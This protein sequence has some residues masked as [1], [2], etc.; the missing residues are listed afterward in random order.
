MNFKIDLSQVQD[1][2][3]PLLRYNPELDDFRSILAD[4]CDILEDTSAA[5]FVVSGFGQAS[6]PVDVGTDL[7]V[8]LEQIPD[9]ISSIDLGVPFSLDFYEQGLERKIHFTPQGETYS[10][11][12]ESWTAWRPDPAIEA[13]D[14]SLLRKMLSAI[15]ERFMN[16][17]SIK[18]P[19]VAAH[20]WIRTW[21][22]ARSSGS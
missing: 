22:D 9:A 20:P 8:L 2:P 16:F 15:R 17:L 3:E 10:A 11:R 7:L 6:W 21:S 1:F 13:I 5:E 18:A 14:T 19:R 12:C 4:I